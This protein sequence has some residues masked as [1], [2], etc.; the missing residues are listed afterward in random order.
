MHRWSNN[1]P[2]SR[3]GVLAFFGLAFCIFMWGLQYKVSL[4]DPPQ[5]LARQVPAAKLLSKNEQPQIASSPTVAPPDHAA[6]AVL[7]ISQNILL[8]L[9]YFIL[10]ALLAA[11]RARRIEADRLWKLQP[12]PRKSFFVR[13]PPFAA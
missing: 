2:F 12:S 13:P 4:Y 9:V 8:L 6:Q 3:V 1:P 5:S 11:F 10:L 7:P